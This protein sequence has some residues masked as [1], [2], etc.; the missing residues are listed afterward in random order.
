MSRKALLWELIGVVGLVGVATGVVVTRRR[1][2][3]K[4]T[5]ESIQESLHE[6]VGV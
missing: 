1:H 6:P 4:L 2:R 3:R 5:P